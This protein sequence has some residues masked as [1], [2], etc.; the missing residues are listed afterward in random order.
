MLCPARGKNHNLR[1]QGIQALLFWKSKFDQLIKEPKK[2][3]NDMARLPS[4]QFAMI[5]VNK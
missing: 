3:H 2:W 1:R 5:C 4:Y